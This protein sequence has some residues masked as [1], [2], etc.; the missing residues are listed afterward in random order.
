MTCAPWWARIAARSPSPKRPASAAA[1]QR[2]VDSP[3]AVELGEIDGLGDLAPHPRRAGRGGRDQPRL[4][5]RPIARN[6]CSSARRPWAALKRAGRPRRVVLVADARPP[7]RR[8][9]V[10]GD[11]ARPLRAVGVHDDQLVAVA[12]RPH[13]LIHELDGTE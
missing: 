7:G 10:A 2:L 11:L 6:A 1:A 3:G 5:A 8:Q 9:R 12:A 4:G 13:A